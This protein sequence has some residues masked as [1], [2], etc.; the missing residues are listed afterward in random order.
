MSAL[1]QSR[2]AWLVVKRWAAD[3][4][5][6]PEL[7]KEL[8][9]I[10]TY[11][12]SDW[13][14]TFKKVEVASD[15]TEEQPVSPVD[16]ILQEALDHG[17]SLTEEVDSATAELSTSSRRAR[18]PSQEPGETRKRRKLSIA[19]YLDIA[20]A[21]DEEDDSLDSDDEIGLDIPRL[22]KVEPAGLQS[23]A[24]N[25]DDIINHYGTDAPSFYSRSEE[26]VSG[27]RCYFIDFYSPYTTRYILECLQPRLPG[28]LISPWLPRRLY[29][30]AC[31]PSEILRAMSP[32]HRDAVRE[33]T[34]VPPEEGARIFST[35]PSI[36]SRCW[37]RI[38]KGKY[39]DDL[40]Y[41]LSCGGDRVLV[42]V[43]PRERPYDPPQGP[44]NTRALFDWKTAYDAGLQLS[45]IE[46]SRKITAF[47]HNNATYFAGLLRLSLISKDL[48]RVLMPHPEQ[49]LLHAQSGID[50]HLVEESHVLFSAQFWIE[51][52]V[53]RSSSPELLDQKA[54]IAA[55]DLAKRTVT[56]ILDGQIHHCPLLE[57][58]RVFSLGNQLRITV[59]PNRSYVGMVV[60]ILGDQLVLCSSTDLSREVHI[61]HYYVGT[62][63]PDHRWSPNG[64]ELPLHH[65]PE[66]V[67]TDLDLQLGDLARVLEGPHCGLRG[68]IDWIH[69]DMV[70]I[71]VPADPNDTQHEDP[72][73]WNLG[74]IMA[75][76]QISKIVSTPV[77]GTLK[78]T[79][80]K[81]Y[82]VGV[83]D[84]VRVARGPH[85]GHQGLVNKVRWTEAC[86]DVVKFGDGV[87]VVVP[88]TWC[89]KF[90]DFSNREASKLVGKEVWIVNGEFKARRATLDTLGRDYSVVS[91]QGHPS[92]NI[93]N[94]HISAP[95]GVLLTGQMLGASRLQQLIQLIRRSFVSTPRAQARTPPPSLQASSHDSPEDSAWSIAPSDRPSSAQPTVP[96]LDYGMVYRADHTMYSHIHPGEIPWVFDDAF[97]DFSKF[98]LA[99]NVD[100]RFM[101]GSFHNR[102][103]RTTCPDRFC[104]TSD[105]VSEPAPPGHVSVTVPGHNRGSGIEHYH[106]PAKFLTPTFPASGGNKQLGLILVGEHAGE[107]RPI[108]KYRRKQRDVELEG[109]W[110]PC[111]HVCP[112]YSFNP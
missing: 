62:Y 80:E 32:S 90:A 10:G 41:V 101:R 18:S 74:P 27:T 68:Y 102:V 2:A 37:V 87:T 82:D 98:H 53:V 46:N 67:R 19:K 89:V 65:T 50:P 48:E 86:L 34:V 45:V 44:R 88:I 39:K 70:W 57:Q 15:P 59:G 23:L 93:S 47:Q 9:S 42:L 94:H 55:V 97:C 66:P 26:E 108:S 112:V 103:A 21:E 91:M 104:R 28:A 96:S 54:T 81:G 49:F 13:R 75:C 30:Q 72:D 109:T 11:N 71:I 95:S 38:R 3:A 14:E 35:E 8:S 51:G 110:Y 1:I 106:I 33:I 36:P 40:G 85:W 12:H 69:D 63:H 83:G 31:S 43:A 76:V 77:F 25:L 73:L 99:F 20:A 100:L 84:E 7:E 52:D 61:S 17:I 22:K 16:I 78:F 29:L 5:S 24:N 92:L 64:P 111:K 4:L 58:R 60:S 6:F 105:G 79:R 56:L 107:V